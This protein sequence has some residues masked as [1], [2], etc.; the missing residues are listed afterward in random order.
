MSAG[1]DVPDTEPRSVPKR[2]RHQQGVAL[3]QGSDL[4]DSKKVSTN[5]AADAHD[6]PDPLP[7]HCPVDGRASNPEQVGKLSGAALAALEQGHQMRFLPAIEL[8]LLATQMPFGLCD[9]H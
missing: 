3:P 9:L 8:G 6:R 2:L 5:G 4:W 1:R 7:F